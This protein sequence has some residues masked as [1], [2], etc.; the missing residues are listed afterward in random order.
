MTVV[1]TAP[2]S[3]A[4]LPTLKNNGY[5]EVQVVAF[6]KGTVSDV[7]SSIFYVKPLSE[8]SFVSPVDQS[9]ISRSVTNI[10]VDINVNTTNLAIDSV[11]YFVSDAVVNGQF[12][13]TTDRKFLVTSGSFDLNLPVLTGKTFTRITALAFGDGGKNSRAVSTQVNYSNA[14]VVTITSPVENQEIN[15]YPS[16]SS[17]VNVGFNV[18]AS[19]IDSVKYIVV[20]VVCNGPGCTNVRR[21]TS[22][23]PSLNLTYLPSLPASGYTEV[24]ATAFSK[25]VASDEVKR[26]F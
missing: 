6:S 10:A 4:Y 7:A 26:V 5:T 25:G 15:L 23:N 9:T 22:K 13:S 14:P 11:I 16:D 20:E 19:T 18:A 12:C 1:K 3:Y 17:K 8:V 2:F 24:Y 21:F